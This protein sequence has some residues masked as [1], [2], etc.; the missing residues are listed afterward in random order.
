[1]TVEVPEIGLELKPTW[2]LVALWLILWLLII[3]LTIALARAG[4]RD[5]AD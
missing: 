4:E 5:D 3:G 2:E 1:M